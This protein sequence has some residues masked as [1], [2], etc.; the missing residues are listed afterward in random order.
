MSRPLWHL[1]DGIIGV[2]CEQLATWDVDDGGHFC[3][4]CAERAGIDDEDAT[5]E[6]PPAW[7]ADAYE[8]RPR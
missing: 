6:A 4:G 7:L 5:R 1:C 8:A 2:G 3:D